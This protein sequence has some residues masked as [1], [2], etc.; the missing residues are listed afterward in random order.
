[1]PSKSVSNLVVQ[2]YAWDSVANT[3]KT[4]DVANHTLRWIKDGVSSAPTNSA[5]EVDSTNAPGVYKITMTSTETNCNIGTLAGKSSTANIVVVPITITFEQL[6]TSAPNTDTGLPIV[7]SSLR[8]S[9]NVTAI[10]GSSTSGNNATLSL[11]SLDIRNSAGSALIAKSTGGN[12]IGIDVAGH[13]TGVGFKVVGGTSTTGDGSSGVEFVGGNAAM[14]YRGGSGLL[15]TGGYPSIS[16]NGG[17]GFQLEGGAGSSF[18]H[19]L[20]THSSN[21]FASYFHSDSVTGLVVQGR[22]ALE[23][24]GDI[25]GLVVSGEVVGLGMTRPLKNRAFDNFMFP[26]FDSITK[27]PLSGLTVTAQRA[28]DGSAYSACSSPVSEIS[29][30]TYRINLS[31][32]DMNG[33]KIM[34]RFSATGADDQLIEIVTQDAGGG[35]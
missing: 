15:S 8:V 29:N 7:D 5:S 24:I 4:G 33:E 13:N 16:G 11:K 25:T 9:S 26:M 21:G 28:I 23:L 18:G 19:G 34:L 14:T 32:S 2:Y 12:G 35:V 30:G 6:P 22:S 20:Y 3:P 31:A 1:M 10:N 27:N 17:H